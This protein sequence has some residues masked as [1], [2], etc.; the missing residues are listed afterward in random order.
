MTLDG[1]RAGPQAEH[2]EDTAY[3]VAV[4]AMIHCVVI[5]CDSSNEG[6]DGRR[7]E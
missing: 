1:V 6:R 4:G 5:S 2:I 3:V 7:G